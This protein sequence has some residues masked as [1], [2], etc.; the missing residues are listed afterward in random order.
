M[1]DKA[2][3]GEEIVSDSGSVVRLVM[4]FCEVT[5]VF[6]VEFLTDALP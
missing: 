2:G 3:F 6:S 4:D 1:F 5:F